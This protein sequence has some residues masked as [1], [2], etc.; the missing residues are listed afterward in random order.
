MDQHKTTT[1]VHLW[2]DHCWWSILA[3]RCSMNEWN[4]LLLI[5]SWSSFFL[6]VCLYVSAIEEQMSM[7]TCSRTRA[8]EKNDVNKQ[9]RK[10]YSSHENAKRS[11][12]SRHQ[13]SICSMED[14]E[15]M[16]NDR[17]HENLWFKS[18]IWRW[19]N[20][21]LL[22]PR[23]RCSSRSFFLHWIGNNEVKTSHSDTR[24]NF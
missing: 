16:I 20:G 5:V 7:D 10:I 9:R 13:I 23:C 8:L 12:S 2:T 17:R 19:K 21:D 6:Q 14:I 11:S 4:L 3:A 24:F 18:F 22:R 1:T 15:Q